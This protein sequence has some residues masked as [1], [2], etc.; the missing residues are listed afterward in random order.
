MNKLLIIATLLLC[1]TPLLAL[2]TGAEINGGG[3]SGMA[4]AP[5]LQRV[6]EAE[7]RKNQPQL[8][9]LGWRIYQRQASYE[10]LRQYLQLGGDP[11]VLSDFAPDVTWLAERSEM[12]L[13]FFIGD[14]ALFKARVTDAGLDPR[15]REEWAALLKENPSWAQDARPDRYRSLALLLQNGSAPQLDIPYSSPSYEFWANAQ[16][17]IFASRAGDGE[18]VRMLLEAGADV[19][20]TTANGKFG[21]GPPVLE[22]ADESTLEVLASAPVD[23]LLP[24]S[25]EAGRLLLDKLVVQT[26]D[27]TASADPVLWRLRWLAEHGLHYGY[28][29]DPELAFQDPLLRARW[30]RDY[31]TA[32]RNP[33]RAAGWQQ[34]VELLERMRR[35]DPDYSLAGRGLTA[36]V[37]P[38]PDIRTAPV[39][40]TGPVGPIRAQ[41]VERGGFIARMRNRKAL[42]KLSGD[43]HD[44]SIRYDQLVEYLQLGG[45]P[46]V[47]SNYVQVTPQWLEYN[48]D[49]ALL[50]YFLVDWQSMDRYFE[51]PPYYVSL[52]LSQMTEKR[53]L[54]ERLRCLQLLLQNGADPT[55]SV[56]SDI[57]SQSWEIE[58]KGPALLIASDY[59]DYEAL[60]LMLAAGADV[61]F[62]WQPDSGPAM[63]PP[64]AEALDYATAE[65]IWAFKPD[66]DYRNDEGLNLLQ[67]AV[68][69]DREAGW[70]LKRLQWMADKGL[71]FNWQ[72]GGRYDPVLYARKQAQRQ[73]YTFELVEKLEQ[74]LR[75]W[76]AVAELLPRLRKR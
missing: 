62:T 33:E 28:S 10:E 20:I 63:G 22:V 76:Q 67:M 7:R 32:E 61:N 58:G 15:Y 1:G 71:R 40:E 69:S 11:T 55:Q 68:F 4:E 13:N 51:L 65:V 38:Q 46:T 3:A 42:R 47:L 54:I 60:R 23:N 48:D 36:E 16:P 53:A 26:G 2:V 57:G 39:A 29:D 6:T 8:S 75:D 18:A 5:Q 49:Q 50:N 31:Y 44:R 34:V 21:Q 73:R 27:A 72:E 12:L 43:I 37:P 30:K 70:V 64:L 9:A 56:G 74:E 45:D 35:L 41:T 19:T 25:L 66:T 24:D 14:G 52:P 59:G 17:L